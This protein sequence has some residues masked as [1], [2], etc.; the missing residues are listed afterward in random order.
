MEVATT[1]VAVSLDHAECRRL[2]ATVEFGRLIFTRGALP[3]VHL[4]RFCLRG[5]QLLM[6][7]HAGSG[8]VRA[9][10][11]AV[12]AF[13][14]DC[15]EPL[16]KTGWSIT[17][18]GPAHVLTEPQDIA[19]GERLGL[20]TWIPAAPYSYIAVEIGLLHG[21]RVARVADPAPPSATVAVQ[22]R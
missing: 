6:P 17:A 10:R 9:V 13:Q 16:T 3:A 18:V 15:V 1:Q 11:G 8:L 5:G 19:A 21:H 14:A 2:L 7:T 20:Q 12:V 4:T 22:P